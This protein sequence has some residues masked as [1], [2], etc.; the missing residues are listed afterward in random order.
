MLIHGGDI[1]GFEE[2]YGCTPLDF[3]V[4]TNPFGMPADAKAAAARALNDSQQY[5]DPLYR[6]LRKAIS[7]HEHIAPE[8]VLCGN[9]AADLIWRI[10][11][12]LRPKR[13]LLTA[14][15]FCE[16][17][18]ALCAQGCQINYVYFR[19]ETDFSADET[20]LASI[21]TD[22][23]IVFLCNPNNPTGVLINHGLL[24]KILDRC[25]QCG[26]FLVVDECFIGFLDDSGR[27][28]LK[29]YVSSCNR[30]LILKAMTKTYAMAGLRL[31]YCFCSNSALLEQLRVSAQSWPVSSVAE[32]AGIAAL[33]DAEYLKNTRRYLA[34][35]RER[36][37]CRLQSQGLRVY[38]GQ[39]NFLMFR[40]DLADLGEKLAAQGILIRDCR[41]YVGLGK[42][43]FRIAIRKKEDNDRL[44]AAMELV[45]GNRL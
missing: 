41:N 28:T 27:H 4:N 10:P 30:L 37:I 36:M 33:Q 42:G 38:P 18:S 3:S 23:D 29:P 1:V 39:A 34:Q 45:R 35:E 21:T 26:C 7:E 44:L 31:G 8:W 32:E 20:I 5:P 15:S 24:L 19:E 11:A 17:A 40:T 9:G 22:I 43:Y 6:R 13:A 14:P 25:R 16:Y 12:V 2:T